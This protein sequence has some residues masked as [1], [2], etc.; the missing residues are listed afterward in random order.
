MTGLMEHQD[1]TQ[2]QIAI[3]SPEV[4]LSLARAGGAGRVNSDIR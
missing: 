4:L 2:E 3:P 1:T